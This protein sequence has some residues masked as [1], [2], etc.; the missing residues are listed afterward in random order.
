MDNK[1]KLL[2]ITGASKGIGRASAA[3]FDAEGYRVI[4]LS[5]SKC[6]VANVVNIKAD[7]ASDDGLENIKTQLM[8]EIDTP[9]EITL[10][11]N[12]AVLTKDSVS[13]IEAD[14]LRAVLNLNV[15]AAAALNTLVIPLMKE[16]SSIIYI[17]ST[18][19][20]KA[21][22][23][24]YAYSISKHAVI[25]QMRATC[26][27][28]AG[29]GIHTACVCPGFTDTEMLNDH[30]GNDPQILSQIASGVALNRLA[31]PS[32]IAESVWFCSQNPVINGSVLHANLGQI[33]H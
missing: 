11:H 6:D 31:Q 19:G 12:A 9:S 33:E 17:S 4:N 5:R 22:A 21:V 30:L 15:V 2:L 7:L 1:N 24:T 23:N 14:S 25:G 26:Q 13:T 20:T 32:E 16:S 10:V 18:L 3:H 27:D 29:T 8:E 28:L